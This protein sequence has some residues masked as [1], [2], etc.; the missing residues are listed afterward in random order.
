MHKGPIAKE[1]KDAF[2]IIHNHIEINKLD[3]NIKTALEVSL[4]YYHIE[5]L[6]RNSN[7]EKL[8]LD[9][10]R[11]TLKQICHDDNIDD[12]LRAEAA[13]ILARSYYKISGYNLEMAR[14]WY[15]FSSDRYNAIMGNYS[16]LF[17]DRVRTDWGNFEA[18]FLNLGC[19][20]QYLE[21]ALMLK[22]RKGDKYGLA[23]NYG[24]LASVYSKTGEF[25]KSIEFFNKDLTLI[26]ELGIKKD[27]THVKCKIADLQVKQALIE[28]NSGLLDETIELL[29]TI[30]IGE[31]QEFFVLKSRLKTIFAKWWLNS[32]DG[33]NL[34]LA[35]GTQETLKD[36]LDDS[37]NLYLQGIFN[38]LAG[39]IEGANGNI[40][41]AS[42]LFEDSA[43][44]FSGVESSTDLPI[45]TKLS[46]IEIQRWLI[47]DYEGDW[48]KD[49]ESRLA[50]LK[51]ELNRVGQDY[52]KYFDPL[53]KK[54][55]KKI[56]NKIR[57]LIKNS[58]ETQDLSLQINEILNPLDK[59][60]WFLEL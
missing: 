51:H 16:P 13:H 11:K 34:K 36:I 5:S 26:N 20:K 17:E 53:D 24:C 3:K 44:C 52:S 56:H 57:K 38:R 6:I 23:I 37:S 19:A 32:E 50:E 1:T 14:E 25:D 43:K 47:I 2:T 29:S 59:L 39:R 22:E 7:Y 48:V 27:I 60:I 35:K 54:D 58:S 30:E 40:Q 15:G 8:N 41:K 46:A 42:L 49:T 33:Y 45:Q 55:L 4:S 31:Q 28:N 9:E 10:I 21:H 18:Q 12:N